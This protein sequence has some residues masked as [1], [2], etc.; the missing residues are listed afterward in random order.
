[1]K[2]LLSLFA[3]LA[4]SAV[5]FADSA[6][7]VLTAN[8]ASNILSSAKIV[9]GITVTATS[10]NITTIRF[11]DSS[12]TS[13]TLVQAAYQRWSSY[14]TNYASVFTNEAGILITNTFRGTWTYPTSVSVAT[15]AKP[16]LVT[17]IV[18]ASSQRTKTIQLLTQKGLTAQA[19]Q[20]AIVEVDY[21]N[22]Q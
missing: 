9:D 8:T 15:N 11:Y 18:P 12:T 17:I 13:T 6:V 10:T 16:T 20:D 21:R 2:T 19:D 22:S 5:S 3:A 7:T 14:Q 4:F 1:M